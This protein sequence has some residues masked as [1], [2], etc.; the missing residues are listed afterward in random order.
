MF[1]TWAQEAQEQ[2]VQSEFLEQILALTRRVQNKK[3]RSNFFGT[4]T[5][6]QPRLKK[7]YAERFD[8]T[9]HTKE[10]I[11]AER[12]EKRMQEAKKAQAKIQ[13]ENESRKL[14]KKGWKAKWHA[15]Q[16]CMVYEN[17]DTGETT[18]SK[19]LLKDCSLN[20]NEFEPVAAEEKLDDVVL[21]RL[22]KEHQ[23]AQPYFSHDDENQEPI[24]LEL[25]SYLIK[26]GFAGD[27]APRVVFPSIV[28]CPKHAK[29]MIGMS[30]KDKYIGDEAQ[31]KRGVLTLK[32]P[33]GYGRIVDNWD[34]LERLLYHSFYEELRVAPEENPVLIIDS[35]NALRSQRQKLTQILFETFN[36]PA[37]YM[38]SAEVAALYASGRTTGLVLKIG[39]RSFTSVAIY[40]GYE[41][42]HSI[43]TIHFGGAHVTDQLLKLLTERGFSFTTTAE[44]D[45][46]RDI[47]EKYAFVSLDYVQALK[48]HQNEMS[49]ELPDG[50]NIIL[51]NELFRCAEFLFQPQHLGMECAGVADAV[52][53]SISACDVDIRKDLFSNIV[54]AGGTTLIRGFSD[55][56]EREIEQRAPSTMRVK[57]IASPERKYA[58][59]I[60]GSIL[61]SLSTFQSF[62]ITKDDYD[63]SGPSIVHRKCLDGN[64]AHDNYQSLSVQPI[65]DKANKDHSVVCVRE[66]ANTNIVA[67]ECGQCVADSTYLSKNSHAA[68]T[69]C[70]AV[71]TTASS[72][73][74]N[75]WTCIFCKS[76]NPKSDIPP[77][78]DSVC[79]YI[80]KPAIEANE[81]T[82]ITDAP[83]MVV[84][85]LDVS[86]SMST[87]V[88]SGSG[89]TRLSCVKAAAEAQINELAKTCPDS[90]V[91]LIAFGSDVT[92][93]V[94][95]STKKFVGRQLSEELELQQRGE[96]IGMQY[97]TPV[98]LSR[99]FLLQ[100]V[101]NLHTTGCTA[102]GPALA[103]AVGM[104]RK[105]PGSKIM[106]LSDGMANCGIGSMNASASNHEKN[107]FYDEMG[108]RAARQS[109]VISICTVEGEPAGLEL[110]GALADATNGIVEIVDPTA[111]A[112]QIGSILRRSVVATSAT[113]RLYSSST[114][115]PIE[116]NYGAV[117]ADTVCI[118]N[119][120]SKDGSPTYQAQFKYVMSNGE[121]RFCVT[122]INPD[123]TTDR[124]IAE[125]S[126][127]DLAI[128]GCSAIRTAA[129]LA[130]T[131]NK[132]EEARIHLISTSRLF[133]RI[134]HTAKQQ[135]NYLA[136]IT[137]SEKLDGFMRE[138][139]WFSE[140]DI[141][142]PSIL[143]RDDAASK[144]MYNLKSL[145]V[146]SFLQTAATFK[147][148]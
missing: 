83:P 58:S 15:S 10:Q 97:K 139:Q 106:I 59:F 12:R 134:M 87:S 94:S 114:N 99:D 8:A 98:V 19:P 33:I 43:N 88:N 104:V 123:V 145:T 81:N 27:D 148:L 115:A 50:Q 37:V 78:T 84:L 26:A 64:C 17:S 18:F 45:I 124:C 14:L 22:A 143:D 53:A 70:G 56:L 117:N 147:I 25:G 100:Q 75:S 49:Y 39:E 52:F 28:G 16:A 144:E 121:T 102:L 46:F 31:S 66:L 34:D 69:H 7:G 129:D 62:W 55:R 38:I 42:P 60:G 29:V 1:Q 79:T 112:S 11:D 32:H 128:V 63:E 3:S 109:T 119:V 105:A 54:L 111:I 13:Q 4:E 118:C 71:L 30:Q 90:I 127:V 85:C 93:Y 113:F 108:K 5:R 2:G 91:V 126:E 57:V 51:G 61:A 130:Y 41:L 122:S 20:Q 136:F 132:Y 82:T 116:Y 73:N 86:C 68:C 23:F 24:I 74:T 21:Q 107:S 137:F 80:L 101:R 96:V 125:D 36:T 35:V 138:R 110:L 77:Q 72:I 133:Q 95:G 92:V 131:D 120:E 6:L 89:Q 40:E 103:V 146:A 47:K 44:R 142:D 141:N 140:H 135:Q 67:F 48:S 76:E 9:C 65:N